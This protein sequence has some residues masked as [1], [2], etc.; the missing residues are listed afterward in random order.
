MDTDRQRLLQE[1]GFA[2]RATGEVRTWFSGRLRKI[3]TEEAARHRTEAQLRELKAE[4]HWTIVSDF[5]LLPD[6]RDRLLNE[7]RSLE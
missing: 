1:L 2:L 3:L 7:A 6:V 5:E 4:D